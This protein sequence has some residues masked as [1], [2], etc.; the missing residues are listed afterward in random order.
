[1][2]GPGLAAAL[3]RAQQLGFVGPGPLDVHIEHSRALAALLDPPPRSFLDLGSGAGLPGLVL[4]LEWPASIGILLEANGRRAE[5]LR[6][7]VTELNLAERLTVVE[8]RAEAAA[9]GQW[10]GSIELVIARSFGPPPVTAEC[11]V[12]FLRTGGRLAVSEPPGAPAGRWDP[13]GLARLGLSAPTIHSSPGVSVAVMRLEAAPEER[14]P[15][16]DGVPAHRP[17]WA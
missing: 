11:G 15:R 14:W 7:S 3:E 5:H 9:R 16:R 17:L 4:A 2:N 10:R 13:G 1:M 6:R 8:A 12:A